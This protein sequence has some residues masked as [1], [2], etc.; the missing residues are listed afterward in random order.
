[1]Q[2]SIKLTLG[3]PIYYRR[4]GLSLSEAVNKA[5]KMAIGYDAVFHYSY[6]FCNERMVLSLLSSGEREGYTEEEKRII[7]SG[8][9]LDRKEWEDEELPAGK[10]LF[11][12]LPFMPDEKDLQ[13]IILPYAVSSDDEFYVRIYKENI[14]ECVFQLLFPSH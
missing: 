7:E 6:S 14:L 11:E 10:Y 13:K 3:S 1:M 9:I 4:T 8:G 12:Q 5:D 2:R